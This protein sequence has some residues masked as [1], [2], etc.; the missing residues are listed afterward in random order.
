MGVLRKSTPRKSETKIIPDEKDEIFDFALRAPSGASDFGESAAGQRRLGAQASEVGSWGE[1]PS[2][3]ELN[4]QEGQLAVDVFQTADEIMVIAPVAGVARDDISISVTDDQDKI[5]TIRGQRHLQ[6]K[7]EPADYFT[8]ECFWGPFSRSIIL[9]DSVDPSSV[10]ASFKNGI[11]T[12]RVPKVEKIKT[13][14]VK[15]KEEE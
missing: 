13:R 14:V 1:R 3:A 8:Q 6:L 7:V 10:K 2:D 11:L 15:I 9:P 5:L 4:Q 12:V